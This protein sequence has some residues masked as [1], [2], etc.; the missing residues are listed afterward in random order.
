MGGAA[1]ASLRWSRTPVTAERPGVVMRPVTSWPST[2]VT[3]GSAATRAERELEQRTT[4]VQDGESR[5]VRGPAQA[6]TAGK[7]HQRRDV[8]MRAGSPCAG[9]WLDLPVQC[10]MRSAG[11]ATAKA[12]KV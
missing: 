12:A 9:K 7:R 2:I 5:R 1:A 10:E 11:G 3:P 8:T 4:R 6:C